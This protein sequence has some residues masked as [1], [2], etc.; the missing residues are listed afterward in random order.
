VI[1][2]EKLLRIFLSTYRAKD[3]KLMILARIIM[4]IGLLIAGQ[5]FAIDEDFYIPYTD[6]YGYEYD[7]ETNKFVKR[8]QAPTSSGN[9]ADNNTIEH[10]QTDVQPLNNQT[11]T[12]A[13]ETSGGIFFPVMEL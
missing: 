1:V 10:T 7:P 11:L 8:D 9:T 2:N 13:E 4:L 3:R 6:T 12:Q 5:V